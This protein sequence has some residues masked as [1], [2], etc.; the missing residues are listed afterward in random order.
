MDAP[1]YD[2]VIE[3]LRRLDAAGILPRVLV[4][5]GWCLPLYRDHYFTGQN[6]RALRTR[7]LDLLVPRRMVSSDN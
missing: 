6:V 1:Q 2:L 4:I 7:D 5:G 3:V